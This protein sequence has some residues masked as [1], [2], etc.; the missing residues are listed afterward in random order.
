MIANMID[1]SPYDIGD[2]VEIDKPSDYEPM[3]TLPSLMTE[4]AKKYS[5]TP[6]SSKKKS[7]LDRLKSFF[8]FGDNTFEKYN[9][10]EK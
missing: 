8:G 1:K 6:Q 4:G 5:A 9:R 10:K 7:F 2:W 3:P